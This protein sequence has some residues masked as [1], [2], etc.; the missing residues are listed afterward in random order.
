[1][2][3]QLNENANFNISD[4]SKNEMSST[5][6]LSQQINNNIIYF[7]CEQSM[8]PNKYKP[9]M[10]LSAKLSKFLGKGSYGSVFQLENSAYVIKLLWESDTKTY[11]KPEDCL[12]YFFW[13][14]IIDWVQT[15]KIKWP[16]NWCEVKLLGTTTRS[17]KMD[18]KWYPMNTPLLLMPYYYHWEDILE[19]QAH[20]RLSLKRLWFIWFHLLKA[21]CYL[22]EEINIIHLDLKLSNIMIDAYGEL[23]IIDFGM[24]E[25]MIT[26]AIFP[27][28]HNNINLSMKFP[29]I[30]Y[31]VLREQYYVWPSG[32]IKL[33]NLMTY[34]LS[35]IQLEIIYGK[36]MYK[37]GGS[38]AN[39]QKYLLD[40]N[41]R[42]Y[43]KDWIEF[44][45]LSSTGTLSTCEMKDLVYQKYEKC[46]EELNWK[47][48]WDKEISKNITNFQ[49]WM[50]ISSHDENFI[51][52]YDDP[53]IPI[54]IN[55]PWN[56]FYQFS[57][58][59]FKLIS[60]ED[61]P[62]ESSSSSQLSSSLP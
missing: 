39:W 51:L 14:K 10:T 56:T 3:S 22:Q 54:L 47:E 45:I 1:M 55:C 57:V 62:D 15:K 38:R 41:D 30:N 9:N 20:P 36:I 52:D 18:N 46:V 2:T 11:E 17:I 19:K 32:P 6:L 40:L 8:I 42:N 13:K 53:K 31:K 60:D 21:M 12:E 26:D 25:P 33:A 37:F 28:Y 48:S 59:P 50:K 16:D 24:V 34:S 29:L 61:R 43:D 5:Q 35:I 4:V 27:R 23:R 44:I 58:S 7:K 49:K